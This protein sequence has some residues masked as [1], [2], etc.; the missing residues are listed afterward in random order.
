MMINHQIRNAKVKAWICCFRSTFS[1]VLPKVLKDILLS[2]DST[3]VILLLDLGAPFDTIHHSILLD[4]IKSQ[5][6]ISWL[7]LG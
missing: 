5:F 1:V 2:L 7:S 3:S 6:A 4:R